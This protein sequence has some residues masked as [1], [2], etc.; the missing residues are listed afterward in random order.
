MNGC[1]DRFAQSLHTQYASIG[2]LHKDF[3]LNR[4]LGM[5]QFVD[6]RDVSTCRKCSPIPSQ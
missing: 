5:C 4:F 2:L 3:R 1:D 6:Q